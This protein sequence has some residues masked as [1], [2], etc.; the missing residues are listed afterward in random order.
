MALSLAERE[1]LLDEIVRICLSLKSEQDLMVQQR[2][3]H[4]LRRLTHMLWVDAD[5]A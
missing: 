5:E 2:L 1:G 3:T 4:D